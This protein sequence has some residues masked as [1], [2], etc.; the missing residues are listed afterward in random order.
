MPCSWSSDLQH[1]ALGSHLFVSPLKHTHAELSAVWCHTRDPTW[2]ASRVP[3]PY[4]SWICLFVH[5]PLSSPSAQHPS[6]LCTPRASYCTCLELGEQHKTG[7]PFRVSHSV[8][9]AA[10]KPIAST[11]TSEPMVVTAHHLKGSHPTAVT[12]LAGLLWK[13]HS[14]QVPS[15]SIL[16]SFVSYFDIQRL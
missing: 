8:G 12:G 16:P 7:F 2:L 9:K 14:C 11:V 1:R 5:V 4:F 10:L 3:V 13:V 6:T 15:Q